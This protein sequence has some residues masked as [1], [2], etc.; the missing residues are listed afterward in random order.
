MTVEKVRR[1]VWKILRA[2]S[3]K[4]FNGGLEMRTTLRILTVASTAAI[5]AA[6]IAALAG[7]LHGTGPSAPEFDS[8]MAVAGIALVG[9]LGAYVIEGFRRRKMK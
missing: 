6:P 8:S 7:G 2:S 5:L 1:S 4:A 3:A 9:G